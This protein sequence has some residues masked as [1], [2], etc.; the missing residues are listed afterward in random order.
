MSTSWLHAKWITNGHPSTFFDM[1]AD[2][3]LQHCVHEATQV[4]MSSRRAVGVRV[5]V[6]MRN[7]LALVQI[8]HLV[9]SDCKIKLI[10]SIV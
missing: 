8:I 7:I 5:C 6:S 4:V 10:R 3:F 9:V 2:C 1:L